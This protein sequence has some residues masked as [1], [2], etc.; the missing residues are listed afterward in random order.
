VTVTLVQHARDLGA[1][2]ARA[3]GAGRLAVDVEANGL[4]AYRAALCTLQL[5]WEEGGEVAVAVVD[6]IAVPVTPLAPLLGP[7]GPVKVLHDLTFDARLLAEAGAPLG[8]ARDTSVAARLLGFTATGLASLLASELGV[9]HAKDLQQHDWSRRP[10]TPTQ[11]DY[12]AGDVRHLLALDD[13]LGGR[14]QALD[15]T[16]EIADEC[17]YK[18]DGALAP[19][20]D[21]R[22]GYARIKGVAALDPQGRAVLRRLCEAREEAAAT[23]DVPP[24]KVIG[25][26]VL[27]ALAQVRPRDHA[28]LAAVRGATTGAAGR[29]T[30]RWLRAVAAGVE[31]GDIPPEDQPLFAPAPPDRASFAQRRAREARVTAWRKAEAARRGV[32]PQAVLPGHCATALVDAFFAHEPGSTALEAAIASI[33][34]L[35]DCRRERYAAALLALSAPAT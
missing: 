31:D 34:G 9:A 14:A 4:H 1:V 7:G 17:A 32:D 22:P 23:A 18:L 25:N 28:A 33:P 2:A 30:D 20:R 6:T 12:L 15:I 21:A 24:F 19:P 5:A 11:L 35:G 16:A 27:L 10:L 3:A 29:W 26:D 8:R 13:L